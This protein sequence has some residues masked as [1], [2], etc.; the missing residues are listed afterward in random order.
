MDLK[1]LLQSMP[2]QGRADLAALC[3]TTAGHLQNVSYGKTCSPALAALLELHTAGQVMRWDMRP[4]DWHVIWP[5][6]RT[7][8]GA[9]AVPGEVVAGEVA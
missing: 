9:P 5:E 2:R 7:R 8:P 3:N 6:L 4:A 1:P